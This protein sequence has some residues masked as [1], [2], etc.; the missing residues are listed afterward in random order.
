MLGKAMRL[1]LDPGK[2]HDEEHAEIGDRAKHPVVVKSPEIGEQV[3]VVHRQ[4]AEHDAG[5]Q[6]AHQRRLT[7]ALRHLPEGACGYKQEEDK[8][9]FHARFQG[10]IGGP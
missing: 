8:E 4:R 3:G 1:Q 6:L 10:L 5:N 7:Q 9:E 2:Q